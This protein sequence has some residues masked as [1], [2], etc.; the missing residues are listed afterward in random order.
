MN[1]MYIELGLMCNRS[2]GNYGVEIEM[3]GD[4]LPRPGRSALFDKMWRVEKDGS[5]KAGEN[6]EYVFNKPMTLAGTRAALTSLDAMLRENKSTVFDTGYAGVHVHLNVQNFNKM[7]LVT[8]ATLWYI[9][10]DHIVAWC[11]EGRV[12]NQFCL[13]SGDAEGVLYNLFE[14]V[15][16]KDWRHLNTDEIRYAAL[17]W[18]SLFKYGSIEFRCMSSTRD[19]D[20]IYRFVQIIDRLSNISKDFE[21]PVQVIS[22]LSM[23]DN[24]NEFIKHIMGEFADELYNEKLSL[25]KTARQIQALV[26]KVDWPAFIKR[27]INPFK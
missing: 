2:D 17:N 26:F 5:L 1:D 3:E 6:F 25:Y 15:T 24:D 10:E 22:A 14:A 9:L 8:L 27:K 23:I 20:R 16:K 7:E 19:M 21:T 11:G 4:K 12:G 18:N 13:S